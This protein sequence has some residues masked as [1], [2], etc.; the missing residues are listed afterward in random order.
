MF[1]KSTIPKDLYSEG[2]VFRRSYVPKLRGSMFRRFY[3]LCSEGSMFRRFYVPKVLCSEGSM[4]RRFYVPKVLC[5]EGSMFR[6]FYV[7]KV[8]CSEG[9]MFR[10][11]I[12]GSIFRR[13]YIPK[14]L[15][16]EKLERFI[17]RRFY[18][19]KFQIVHPIE[20]ARGVG[21]KT[22]VVDGHMHTG[23]NPFYRAN[24]A[25]PEW[26]HNYVGSIILCGCVENKLGVITEYSSSSSIQYR[27]LSVH[28]V[29]GSMP[30]S[31]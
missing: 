27:E 24:H 7:P 26:H 30:V 16:S 2:P 4:F 23:L 25:F 21:T 31:N 9:S 20:S 6:R 5:S 28:R 12:E 18:V 15:C 13:F 19:P 29:P 11:K 22:N 17:F 8:L 14:V 3:V 10:N 1:R